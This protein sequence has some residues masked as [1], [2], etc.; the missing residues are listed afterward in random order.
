MKLHSYAFTSNTRAERAWMRNQNALANDLHKKSYKYLFIC[1]HLHAA[2]KV[3]T[4]ESEKK[5]RNTL[6]FLA[7]PFYWHTKRM[8]KYGI[9]IFLF[10]IVF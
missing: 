4:R 9:V 6:P 8:H 1:I 2:L 3:P 7:F 10:V 5:C